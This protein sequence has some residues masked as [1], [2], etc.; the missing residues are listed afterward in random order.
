MF[1]IN[2]VMPKTDISVFIVYSRL[3]FVIAVSKIIEGERGY[4]QQ[5][6]ATFTFLRSHFR[7]GVVNM[8]LM[9]VKVQGVKSMLFSEN[10]KSCLYVCQKYI[11][12]QQ[13]N[14]RF[15]I[16]LFGES[17]DRMS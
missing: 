16:S 13:T 1:R 7:R 12:A 9:N 11:C 4:G 3:V 10:T 2:T 15:C 6:L 8:A 14:P 17:K 5:T